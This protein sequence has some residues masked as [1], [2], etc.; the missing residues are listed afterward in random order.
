MRHILFVDDDR[1]LLDGLRDALRPRRHEW[2]MTFVDGGEAAIDVFERGPVDIVVSDLRMPGMDGGALLARVAQIKPDAVR[3]VLSGHAEP[4][5]IGRIAAVAHRILLK[6]SSIDVIAR[7][8]ERSC[9]LLDVTGDVRLIQA[10]RTSELPSAPTAYFELM[11]LLGSGDVNAAQ[12]AAVLE[13]DIAMSVKVLQ[14]ANS[15]YFGRRH[16]VSGLRDA[17]TLLGHETLRALALSAEVFQK[18]RVPAIAGFS[19]EGVQHRSLQV[20]RLAHTLSKGHP[21]A[22]DAFAAGLLLNVGLLVLAV[23]EPEYL[24]EVLL[25]AK[26]EGRPVHEIERERH[27][28]TH[29]EI[30]AHLLALWGLP[31]TIV[32]AV[33]HHHDPLRSPVPAFDA[34]A[35]AH[36]ADAL[37]AD[38]E[39]GA[40]HETGISRIDLDYLERIDVADRLP[41]WQ[42]LALML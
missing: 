16:P 39:A 3:I 13:R 41:E 24:A 19:L 8:I 11:E 42:R 7:V 34:V 30:G 33:A 12:I 10:A 6:P 23:R 32:E 26:D 1:D 2:R 17:V 21:D 38:S 22:D 15:A 20:G 25:A 31:H 29:A 9:V 28:I 14:L 4:E 27:G 36:I 18:F 5:T 35:V 37:V 40:R